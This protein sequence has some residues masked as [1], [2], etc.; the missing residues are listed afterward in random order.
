MP[1][2]LVR[3]LQ[4]FAGQ[5]RK[6]G[7]MMA[8][9]IA[10][11]RFAIWTLSK[12]YSFPSTWHPP[13][14]ARPYRIAIAR[15]VNALSPLTV[16]EI[17][18]G[19]GSILSRIKAPQRIGYDVDPGVVRAARLIRSRRIEFHCGSI[20]DVSEPRIDVL[21]LVNWI[22]EIDPDQLSK[23][24]L[25]LLDRVRY[26]VLDAID[27]GCEGYRHHHDFCFLAGRATERRRIRVTGEQRSFVVYEVGS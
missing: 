8:A 17:G 5:A 11:D 3:K 22:H 7:L 24:L 18:C 16:C 4:T 2:A 25:P 10:A 13:T 14:S 15:A 23:D 21:I 19:I 9:R 6:H 1:Y 26:V 12:A 27:P 20:A